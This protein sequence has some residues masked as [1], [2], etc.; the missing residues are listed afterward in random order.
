MSHSQS[1]HAVS[2]VFDCLRES[3]DYGVLGEV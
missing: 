2:S 1:D 3:V